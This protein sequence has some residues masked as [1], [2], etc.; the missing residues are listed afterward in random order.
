M[1]KIE[2]LLYG[3]GL[4]GVAVNA[5]SGVLEA[6]RK[7]FD[8][9]GM[10]VVALAAALGGGTLRDL[11]L[12]R[13]VFWIADQSYLVCAILAGMLSF[14]AA[15]YWRLPSRLFLLPDALGLALFTVSG[16][17]IALGLGV[18]WLVASAMGVITGVVGGIL[19]DVLCNE[20]PLIFN[21]PLYATPAWF[22]ALLLVGLTQI[23]VAA[24][25]AALAA[26]AFVLLGRLLALRYDLTL[27]TYSAR[28]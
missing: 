23:G 27:P 7:P 28:L 1:G 26:G 24:V 5:A 11:L 9:F 8:M 20:E 25:P 22:G 15:R 14:A 17:K 4:A 16:T 2:T 10:V 13:T 21:G 18:P 6:G 19:R 12:D 3:I